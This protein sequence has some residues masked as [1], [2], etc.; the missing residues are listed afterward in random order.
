M[1]LTILVDNNAG[2]NL[3]GEWGLSFFIEADGRNILFDTG[4]SD[5]FLKNA[6]R[7]KIDLLS[8][9]YLIFS[10]G[11]YDHTWGLDFLLQ[12][13]LAARITPENRP[14]LIAHPGTF[15]PKFR[16]DG[17][18]FGILL[19][20]STLKR[21]FQTNLTREPFQLT[22]NLFFLGEIPRKFDFEGKTSLGQTLVSDSLTADYLFD[23]T[24]LVYKTSKGLI[25]ITGCSHSGVCNIVEH[26]RE[27]CKEERVI[28]IIGG[29]HLMELK[30][31]DPKLKGA[32][33]YLKKLNPVQIHPCHCTDL[34]CKMAL[35]EVS[36][37]NEACSGLEL[38]Y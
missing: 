20:Q 31:D 35:A 10:H 36:M 37:V 38:K 6:V 28:D 21:N 1:R 14:A 15:V 18:E 12:N 2:H 23:D 11:H 5:L 22:E 13:Y 17:N 29:F 3:A 7:L 16:D 4:A 30:N 24:A 32:S 19:S 34:H 27:V 33:C 26:A 8:L 25:V 9:D